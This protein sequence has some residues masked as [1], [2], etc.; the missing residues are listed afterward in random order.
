MKDIHLRFPEDQLHEAIRKTA[1]NNRRSINSEILRA[2]DFY[3]KNA[4]EAQHEE[5]EVEKKTTK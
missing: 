2:I 3:L 4:P 5:K 1:E